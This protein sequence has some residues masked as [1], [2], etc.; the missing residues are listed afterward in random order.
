[1]I[2]SQSGSIEPYQHE[3]AMVAARVSNANLRR[4]GCN[5]EQCDQACKAVVHRPLRG[6]SL[7]KGAGS[8]AGSTQTGERP[9]C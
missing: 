6:A 1:M 2:C 7:L 5:A 9:A 3:A 4:E 8:R